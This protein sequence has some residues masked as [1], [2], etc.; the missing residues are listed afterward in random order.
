MKKLQIGYRHKIKVRYYRG[1]KESPIGLKVMYIS[2]FHFNSFSENAAQQ[3]L[4]IINQ[5]SPEILLLGGDYV[6]TYSGFV[7]FEKVVAGLKS[8]KNVYAIAGNH[9]Y[10]YGIGR[11]QKTCLENNLNWLEKSSIMLEISGFKIQIDNSPNFEFS[12]S[13]YSILCLHKPINPH[14]LSR[15]YDLI[16]AGHLH[17]SQIVIWKNEK[18][19][20]PGLFFYKWNMLEKQ[21]GDCLYVISKGVGDTLPIRFDC[22]KDILLIE[23]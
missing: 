16:L 3:I 7:F 20:F 22:I 11:I 12:K 14:S 9:D 8:Q 15:K 23:I 6:D 5:Y 19:L 1:L 2:D 10:F 13:D 4:D 21:I 18:G 17:G